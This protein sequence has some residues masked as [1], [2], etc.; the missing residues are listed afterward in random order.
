MTTTNPTDSFEETARV[1]AWLT[2]IS[3]TK[4]NPANQIRDYQ[5]LRKQLVIRC[6]LLSLAIIGMFL[7]Y[8]RHG[9][10][11]ETTGVLSSTTFFTLA[12]PILFIRALT[13]TFRVIGD[14]SNRRLQKKH[15]LITLLF[16]VA[17]FP[18]FVK[19]PNFTYGAAQTLRK[20]SIS[21]QLVAAAA[22]EIAK[23]RENNWTL[24][25]GRTRQILATDPFSRLKLRYAHLRIINSSLIFGFGSPIANRWGFAISG[26]KG[27]A[28]TLPSYGVD[29]KMVSSEIFVFTDISD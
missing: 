9:L 23:P 4:P 17:L 26:E 13:S 22:R 27:K 3:N 5:R 14:H 21:D 10:Q 6:S 20:L 25:D 19:V 29:P 1:R 2:E 28:P 8:Y 15:L 12:I 18:Y 24:E 7:D 16:P 11:L